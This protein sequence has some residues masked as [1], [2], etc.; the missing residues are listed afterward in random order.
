MNFCEREAAGQAVG[1]DRAPVCLLILGMHRSGTS[2]VARIMS[3]AGAALPVR[4]MGAG[5]G[6]ETGHWEPL[7]VMEL[8]DALLK[9]VG[10][11]WDDWRPFDPSRLLASRRDQVKRD[12][13]AILEADYPNAS[14]FVVKEPRICR[15]A[16]LYLEAL[17]EAGCGVRVVLPFRNP[18][19][20]CASLQKRTE[21]WSPDHTRVHAMLM[22]LRHVLEAEHASRHV[23]R[24]FVSYERLLRE[25]VATFSA[26]T[27]QLGI[28]WPYAIGDV[29]E[30]I[31][32]FLA[33]ELRHNRS[34]AEKV[35]L[36]PVLRQ[37]AAEAF[38]ALLV[39]ERNPDSLHALETLDKIRAEL[40]AASPILELLQDE[41]QRALAALHEQHAAAAARSESAQREATAQ[42]DA[43]AKEAA[44]LK[45]AL[46]ALR[47][48]ADQTASIGGELAAELARSKEDL[49]QARAEMERQ[50]AALDA[51]LCNSRFE[52]AQAKDQ[53]TILTSELDRTTMAYTAEQSRLNEAAAQLRHRLKE[54]DGQ[55]YELRA[56]LAAAEAGRTDAAE[57]YAELAAALETATRERD[58][59]Q[60]CIE[61]LTENLAKNNR[62]ISELR[63]GQS[64][65]DQEKSASIARQGRSQESI[66]ELTASIAARDREIATLRAEVDRLT[67]AFAG[68]QR[69]VEDTRALRST[70]HQVYSSS[71]WRVTRPLR[72]M[73]SLLNRR[74][75]W[76]EPDPAQWADAP[77]RP[78]ATQANPAVNAAPRD[79]QINLPT[80]EEP[81]VSV[82]IPVYGQ[83]DYTLQCL[84]SI[85]ANPP[86]VPFEIIVVDDCSPD[87][88]GKVLARIP[89]L[90]LHVN[91]HNL[92]FVRSCNGAASIARGQYICLLNNDTE[93]APRWLDELVETFQTFPNCGLVG[94]K[95]VYPD[96]RLQEV[97]GIIWND[98]SAWNY[99]RGE[100][101]TLPEFNY[102]REVDY[103]SGASIL[104]PIALWRELGGFDERYVPAYAEDSD[105]AL[106]IRARGLSVL[107][108]PLSVVVHYEGVS[109]GTD[110]SKGGK[111][112]QVANARK[113]RDKWSSYLATLQPNGKQL[114][115]AKDRGVVRRVLVIDNC[116]PTPDQ[117][118]GSITAANLI[119][120]LDA[121]RFQVTMIPQDNFLYDQKY[122]KML[123]RLG[124][125]VEYGRA[126]GSVRRHVE[127]F[128]DRY[129]LVVLF[130]PD[131]YSRHFDDI[132]K[133][134]G[135]AKV[136]YHTADLHH[137]RMYREVELSGS[138]ALT[139]AAQAMEQRELEAIKRADLSIVH[140]TYERD[141][142]AQRVPGS[143]VQVFNWAIPVSVST[144]GFEPRDGVGF[145]G[146]FQHQPNADAVRYFVA[147]ILPLLLRRRPELVFHVVGSKPP[148]DIMR[149]ANANIKV[150]GFVENIGPLLEKLRLAVVPL[151]YGAG[152]KGKLLTTMAAG[153]P[154]VVTTV[155]AEGMGLQHGVEVLVADRPQEFAEQVLEMYAN[156]QLWEKTVSEGASYASEAVGPQRALSIMQEILSS[157]GLPK[158]DP[159]PSGLM[160][161][162]VRSRYVE[163]R[164]Q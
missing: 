149:M 7:R 145:I 15:F 6:N 109:H 137:L 4:L 30:R 61:Q 163:C 34:S 94:S 156:R 49:S 48:E 37:W 60:S 148:E 32:E 18:I 22:W 89:K 8:N 1:A 26:L 78:M 152:V 67:S 110:T 123:Q 114:D 161:D 47:K 70:L 155:A 97:G 45:L 133:F 117:D 131:G 85:A 130:R 14:L 41:N 65:A 162:P 87:D 10:S 27:D 101:P 113:L 82:I 106:Q 62:S 53:I 35:L 72:K 84:R 21:V 29:S 140:S 104:V 25:P 151:R 128:G 142:L 141:Y 31:E 19:E 125:E 13:R 115:R 3:I 108:N 50:L 83:L 138:N 12:I 56:A 132:R 40:D 136:V 92:G 86:A 154:S 55:L 43:Q 24:A 105:L 135:H 116:L 66:V 134:C 46:S 17:K 143:A 153:L 16:S 79:L 28:A 158:L 150:H 64:L 38:E 96:G 51:E 54:T 57:R 120:L 111:A 95:L 23:A 39:L 2:A 68:A 77:P 112:H 81:L 102:V 74:S 91:T 127:L 160:W 126:R 157:V 59:Q 129:D 58:A 75:G 124:V 63:A 144:V 71:S 73:S 44:E 93:I 36:D 100:D 20:V 33:P 11:S 90:R 122:T 164:F 98:G 69:T 103:V 5:V 76:R 121:L 139:S 52:A 88:S 99:G 147:E 9:E 119:R 118:A 107:V 146:G 80:S 42:L 159:K